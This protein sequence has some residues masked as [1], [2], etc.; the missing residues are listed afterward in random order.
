MVIPRTDFWT[1]LLFAQLLPAD[2]LFWMKNYFCCSLCSQLHYQCFSYSGRS[3]CDP[4]CFIIKV[5]AHDIVLYLISARQYIF[6]LSFLKKYSLLKRFLPG[7]DSHA[8]LPLRNL[9][10][11]QPHKVLLLLYHLLL[12]PVHSDWS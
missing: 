1:A 9:Q 6:R 12:K 4:N 3:P 10:P 11:P 7:L 8:F 2:L 5:G